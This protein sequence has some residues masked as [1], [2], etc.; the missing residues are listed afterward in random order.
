[1]YVILLIEWLIQ[2][3]SAEIVVLETYSSANC[4]GNL[5]NIAAITASCFADNYYTFNNGVLTSYSCDSGS[6]CTKGCKGNTVSTSCVS[7]SD[8]SLQ[9]AKLRP[10]LKKYVPEEIYNFVG[11]TLF[12][13]GNE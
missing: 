5:R 9:K 10:E 4:S 6:N 8:G 2:M 12:L 13:S 3:T 1:M 7:N 11:E